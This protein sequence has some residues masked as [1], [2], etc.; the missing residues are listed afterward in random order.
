MKKKQRLLRSVARDAFALVKLNLVFFICCLPLISIP[1]ALTAMTKVN[2][3]LQREEPVSVV[4]DFF[5]TFRDE[6]F[7]SLLCGLVLA[8]GALLFGYVFWFYQTMAVEGNAAVTLLRAMTAL[9]LVL[10]YCAAC[11]LWVM[12]AVVELSFGPRLRNALSLT[13]VSLR[14]TLF[15]LAAGLLFGSLATLGMPYAS[16]FFIVAGF[17]LWNYCC[18]FY[19][20]PAVER[21]ILKEDQP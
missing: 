10:C 12:N 13:V 18:T 4:S 17:S 16:P 11:Y 1:A 20:L 19:A 6:F 14:S 2:I 21:Y 3:L 9:P 15:C 8:G 7:D 5:Q